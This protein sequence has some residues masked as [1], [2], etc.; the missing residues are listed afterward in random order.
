MGERV[1]RG[2]LRA[3]KEEAPQSGENTWWSGEVAF[4]EQGRRV[5]EP[6]AFAGRGCA[7]EHAARSAT[8]ATTGDNAANF[9]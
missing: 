1:C 5:A 8:I 7:A 2:F 3:G 6:G 9:D 4:A